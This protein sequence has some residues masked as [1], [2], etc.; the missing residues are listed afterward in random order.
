V[1]VTSSVT[2]SP[3]PCAALESSAA[4]PAPEEARLRELFRLWLRAGHLHP[5]LHLIRQFDS[6]RRK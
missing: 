5:L 6:E 1:I 4:Q 3:A 2:V